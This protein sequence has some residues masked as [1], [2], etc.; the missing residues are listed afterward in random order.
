LASP[1][2]AKKKKFYHFCQLIRD[3]AGRA[4]KIDEELKF[5]ILVLAEVTTY[6]SVGL[7][8]GLSVCLSVCLSA[9]PL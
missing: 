5:N 4:E 7:S 8:V 2:A 6:L 9:C 1:S 3:G